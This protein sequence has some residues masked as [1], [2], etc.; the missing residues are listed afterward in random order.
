[1]E[2]LSLPLVLKNGHF[3]RTSLRNSLAFSVGMILCTRHGMMPFEPDFGCDIWEKEFSD[4]MTAN[5]ADIRSNLRNALDRYEKRLY[6]VSV[7]LI[8]ITD[9]TNLAIGMAVKV[10][11]N[12]ME[13]D[14]EQ[15]FEESFTLA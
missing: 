5:K 9:D 6:N 11:G 14:Q 2:Y 1:M 4:I 10:K 12:Y 3:D 13:N 15:Q 7:S 8:N